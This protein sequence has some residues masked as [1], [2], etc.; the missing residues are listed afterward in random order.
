LDKRFN[1]L[2]KR[3]TE[4]AGAELPPLVLRG[5]ELAAAAQSHAEAAEMIDA[6]AELYPARST[7]TGE[8]QLFQAVAKVFEETKELQ[9]RLGELPAGYEAI[10]DF[11][12]SVAGLFAPLEAFQEHV[13][14]LARA[15]EPMKAVQMQVA[16]LANNFTAMKA[17]EEQLGQLGRAFQIHL[18]NLVKALEP[19]KGLHVRAARLVRMLEPAT[20]LQGEFRRLSDRFAAPPEPEANSAAPAADKAQ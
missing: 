9:R 4:Q 17:L 1:D 5:R 3:L 20:L 7:E 19:A 16:Q 2:R 14:E 12:L 18:D 11:A 15:C 6:E 13:T 8:F 10:E